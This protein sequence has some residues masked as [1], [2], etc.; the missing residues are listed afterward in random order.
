MIEPFLSAVPVLAKL[1]N[2]GYEAYFVGGSVR[3]YL[4]NKPIHDIDI[5]T[6]ATP[7]EMKQIFSKTIDLGIEHGTILVLYKNH[8]YEITTFRTESE[9]IDYRRPKEVSFIRSLKKDL[10]RRDFTINA[11]AMDKQGKIFD[12]FDGQKSLQVREIKTV[13]NADERFREDA[14]RIMRAVRFVSQLDFTIEKHTLN[15]IMGLAFLLEN[16]AVERKRTEFEKL[17]TGLNRKKAMEVIIKTGLFKFLPGL[18]NRKEALQKCLEF[19]F[20]D[21][22]LNEMWTL[23]MY[24]LE[25]K[26]KAAENFL[27]EWRL[28]VKQIRELQSNLKFLYLRLQKEWTIQSL[29]SAD[30][31]TVKSVEQLYLAINKTNDREAICLLESAYMNLPIKKRTDLDVNGSD[32]MEWFNKQGGSWI[33]EYFFMIEQAVLEGKV[34]NMKLNIKEWLLKCNQR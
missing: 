32:L 29:Y 3:D 17:L 26:D 18:K 8:S 27:R 25:L 28:P 21:L 5:A 9:Y 23:L 22:S 34:E 31:E 16:I 11:M 24:C 12:L 4:L 6:S 30:I 1:E 14:L 7:S 19:N 2:A 13:G 15:A 20:K 33:N 10:E